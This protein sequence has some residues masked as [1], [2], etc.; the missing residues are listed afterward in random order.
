MNDDRTLV[1]G[2]VILGG[3]G[4]ALVL[5]DCIQSAGL[6]DKLAILD[7]DP[8]RRG[9]CIAG[10]QVIGSDDLL[11]TLAAT[12]FSHF[13]VGIGAIGT[14]SLR[15]RLFDLAS[16][17]GLIPLTVRHPTAHVS[18]LAQ[19]AAGAQILAGA[20][21][22]AKAVIG[23]NAIIN[24][25]AIVEH[26]CVIGAHVHVASGA[27]LTG[28]VSVCECT[29]VGAGAIVRQGVSI[30]RDVIIGAG[31]VVIADVPAGAT[32]VGVP[33]RILSPKGALDDE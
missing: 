1:R 29:L 3:G 14:G 32:V 17:A 2:C 24:T 23:A 28:G 13:V 5:V 33:A 26:D 31:A 21:V 7:R 4:H 6:A 12:G 9:T 22:N 30:A 25:G 8:V 27:T 20:L 16:S 11:P 19:V 15:S 18:T 10:V